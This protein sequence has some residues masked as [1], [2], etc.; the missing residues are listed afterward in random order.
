MFMRYHMM[1]FD[2]K[3]CIVLFALVSVASLGQCIE[4][5]CTASSEPAENCFQ[6]IFSVCKNTKFIVDRL[7]YGNSCSNISLFWG[8]PMNNMTIFFDSHSLKSYE[9]CISQVACTKAFYTTEDRHEIPIEWNPSNEEPVCFPTLNGN[10]PAMRFR[11][12][13]GDRWICYGTTINFFYKV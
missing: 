6:Y 5:D 7:S 10:R 9:L 13:A 2:I 8:G 1:R 12:D 3:F 4:E 11:F